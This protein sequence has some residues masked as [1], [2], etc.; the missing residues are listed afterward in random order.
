M[1][2]NIVQ[3]DALSDRLLR[4]N[5]TCS[6]KL[7]TGWGWGGFSCSTVTVELSE[8]EEDDEVAVVEEVVRAAEAAVGVV[9]GVG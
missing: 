5:W 9:S 8:E 6:H 2:L 3:V 4:A 7:S 1:S